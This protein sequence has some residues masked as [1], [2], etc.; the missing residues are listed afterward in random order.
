MELFETTS[1]RGKTQP[2]SI[3][4]VKSAYDTVKS[5][6]GAG[7]VDGVSLP[8]YEAN[9]VNLLYTLWNRMASGSY[10]PE[11][12][13]TVEIPKSDGSKRQLGIPTI[14][15]R[16]AQQVVKSVLEPR[17]EAVFH[18]DSYG[19]RPHKSAHDAIGMC[20]LRCWET[21]YVI[22]LDIKGFF[23]NIDHDLMMRVV[24][25]YVSEEWILLYVERWLKAPVKG[26]NGET[27][28]R[29][30]GTP[31]GG[32]ISPLLSNM[33]LHVVF[34]GWI[35]REIPQVKWERY[36][37]DIILHCAS[38]AEAESVLA[39]VKGRLSQVGLSAHEGKT[40]IVYCK[41]VRR[42]DNYPLISFD[43]LGYCFRPRKC[44]DKRGK[45]FLGFTPS[46]SPKASQRI[47]DEIRKLRLHRLGHLEL[48]IIAKQ[49]ESK[50]RG[51]H[52][53]YGKF[54]PSGFDYVFKSWFNDLLG[55]WVRNKYKSCRGSI[56]QG[57]NKLKEIYTDFP[58][59]F[60]HWQYG[61]HPS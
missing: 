58:T 37:D 23:D 29:T 9:K 8:D 56:S 10:F 2:I 59:L 34:D 5:N 3:E 43:F 6:G 20:R 42:N 21:L 28:Q 35:S 51:W 27:L 40:K 46:I 47:R 57:M 45:F 41:S 26:L 22:D 19:Y 38:Q 50:L 39:R 13:R 4:Q 25:H 16:I 18:P 15:D 12:V 52:Y 32:V 33:Y 24:R 36:A 30:K 44:T 17:M 54:T 11:A 60:Y 7:G 61:Y 1:L 49:L 14:G 31:Q 53:Y 55:S 48:P